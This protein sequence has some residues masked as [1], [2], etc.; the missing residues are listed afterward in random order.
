MYMVL[1]TR[2][3]SHYPFKVES[4]GSNPTRITIWPSSEVGL[5]RSP[6]TAKTAG[7]SPAWVAIRW[8]HSY[9]YVSAQVVAQ[10]PLQKL[11]I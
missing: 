3:L 5:S 2:G 7:S 10:K 4:L 1:S 8:H 11:A 6:V 9:V